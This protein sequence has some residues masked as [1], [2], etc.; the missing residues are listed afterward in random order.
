MAL[1]RVRTNEPPLPFSRAE[2]CQAQRE[3]PDIGPTLNYQQT[4]ERPAGEQ[5]KSF[6]AKNKRLLREWDKLSLHED[7]VLYRKTDTRTQLVLPEK[8][9][10]DS[11]ETTS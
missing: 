5:L 3:D 11:T 4:N 9:Y 10:H 8:I 7:G 2:I 6:S 1:E